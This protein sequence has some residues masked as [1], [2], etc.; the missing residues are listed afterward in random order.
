[1]L[2]M[3]HKMIL[4]VTYITIYPNIIIKK[5]GYYRQKYRTLKGNKV[6]PYTKYS[7]ES[8]YD[9][10]SSEDIQ[11]LINCVSNIEPVKST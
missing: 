1:M 4:T 3:Q 11:I 10:I 5:R 6:R 8:D 9:S 2:K 7:K